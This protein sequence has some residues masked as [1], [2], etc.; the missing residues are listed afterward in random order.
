MIKILLLSYVTVLAGCA[1]V[2]MPVMSE[3]PVVTEVPVNLAEEAIRDRTPGMSSVPPA[4][5]FMPLDETTIG[6]LT[7]GGDIKARPITSVPPASKPVYTMSKVAKKVT[8]A[9]MTSAVAATKNETVTLVYNEAGEIQSK[10]V[11]VNSSSFLENLTKLIALL[12]GTLGLY[13]GWKKLTT[14]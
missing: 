9:V 6:T 3:P 10:T 11:V 13:V 12:T 2:T 8:D 5:A 4:F 14:T 1:S 7:Y